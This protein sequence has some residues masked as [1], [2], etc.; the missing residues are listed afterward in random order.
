MIKRS[1][2]KPSLPQ[3][4][5]SMRAMIQSQLIEIR[6][7]K[8]GPGL[9]EIQPEIMITL[10]IICIALKAQRIKETFHLTLQE[11]GL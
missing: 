2:A 4:Q 3:I 1:S 10:M 8:L 6:A 7:L 9:L 5:R 11:T